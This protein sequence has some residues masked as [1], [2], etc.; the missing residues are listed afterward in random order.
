MPSH[1]CCLL[2]V[3]LLVAATSNLIEH[4][5]A[6]DLDLLLRGARIGMAFDMFVSRHPE[7]IY[8]DVSKRAIP[9]DPEA[10][11]ALLITH[12]TDPFLET[13]AF[14]NFGFRDGRLYELVTVWTGD[15]DTMH[16][17]RER[18]FA[19][20]VC[21]HGHA[22]VR[23]TILVHPNTVDELPVAVFC[24]HEPDAV[25]LAFHTPP[26]SFSQHTKGVFTYAQFSPGDPFLA[27]ILDKEALSDAQHASAW[28]SVADILAQLEKVSAD[29]A[30]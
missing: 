11:E 29:D 1:V 24:W 17:R 3:L 12:E 20:A 18:F 22:Y 7:A 23:E 19:A 9:V 28:E 26:S 6:S 25:S 4:N 30:D 21:R 5:P 27:D 8:S 13:P 2:G 14:A 10:P 15:P 16:A